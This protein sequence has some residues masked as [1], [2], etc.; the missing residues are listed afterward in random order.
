MYDVTNLNTERHVTLL[1]RIEK[2]FFFRIVRTITFFVAFMALIATIAG[3]YASISGSIEAKPK[4]VQVKKEEI[5]SVLKPVIQTSATTATNEVSSPIEV[6]YVD[7]KT[8]KLKSIAKSIAK[9]GLA[10]RDIRLD[11]PNYKQQV[12]Q[13]TEIILSNITDYDYDTELIVLTRLRELSK[14]FPKDKFLDSIDVYFSLFKSKHN[15]EQVL[16]KQKNLS[17]QANKTVGYQAVGSGI[18]IFALFVMIL[19]LLRIEKNTRSASAETDEYDATDK[20]LLIGIIGF[21]IAIALLIGWGINKTVESETNF[22][23]VSDVYSSYTAAQTAGGDTV[24][25]PEA[26]PEIDY[27][28][29]IP[30]PEPAAPAY[31]DSEVTVPAAEAAPLAY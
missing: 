1:E 3:L 25:T 15:H 27:N 21:A 26:T 24:P 12:E 6:P 7:P 22:D 23:A 4:N 20:K 31:N 30:T 17:A 14:S 18:V 9:D 16:A 10:S 8:A 29:A 13:L 28:V 11:T 5:E 2:K 19:V